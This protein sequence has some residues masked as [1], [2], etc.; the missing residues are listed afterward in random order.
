MT[1]ALLTALSRA[2]AAFQARTVE[3]V[4]RERPGATVPVFDALWRARSEFRKSSVSEVDAFIKA[5]YLRK[6][7]AIVHL[8]L[9]LFVSGSPVGA[10]IYAA[11]PKQIETRY[12]GKTWELAR[13]Y[14]LDEIPRNAETFVIGYSVRYIKRHYRDV[15]FLVSYADPSAGHAGTIYRAANW[16]SDGMT[17]EGRKSPRCD[18]MDTR[19]G[20]KYGR[21]GNVPADA[22]VARVPR[23]SKFRFY[24]P[25]SAPPRPPEPPTDA[26]P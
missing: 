18:Y 8:C 17:D 13:L 15:R 22:L 21:R 24:Y 2:K 14:L 5:H 16:L 10:I 6:R 4:L 7:P 20:K 25:L 26:R 12:G 3:M 19:T 23:V 1:Q 11:P 9:T